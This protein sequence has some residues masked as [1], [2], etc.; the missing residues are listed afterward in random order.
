[1]NLVLI[2]YRGSGKTVVASELAQRTGAAVVDADEEIERAAGRTIREIFA[3]DGEEAFRDIESRVLAG[4]VGRNGIVLAAGGGAVLREGN[5]RLLKQLGTVIWLQADVDTILSRV[6]ADPTTMDRRPNLTAAGGR[7]EVSELLAY[8]EPLYR[9]CADVVIDTIGRSLEQVA[10]AI[11][12]TV[13]RAGRDG[14]ARGAGE[15][16]PGTS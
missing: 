13:R 6:T 5:R 10:D 14:G 2:G 12:D 15:L 4:L 3:R 7:R 8:R 11:L 1:M 9:E 16:R